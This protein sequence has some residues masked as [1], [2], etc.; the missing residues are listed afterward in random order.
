MS[1]RLSGPHFFPA[2]LLTALALVGA[3]WVVAAQLRMGFLPREY[4]MWWARRQT[5]QACRFAPTVILGDSRAAAG[6]LP[7]RIAGSTNLAQ[8]G[9]SPIET[10]YITQDILT[11]PNAPRRVILSLSPE[12]V[13]QP[14][15]F[16]NRTGLYGVLTFAQLEEI[17]QRSRALGDTSI[18]RPAKFGDWDAMLDNLLHAIDFPSF[19]TTYVVSELAIGRLRANRATADET[20]RAGGQHGYGTADGCDDVAADAEIRDFVPSPLLREYFGRLLDAYAARGIPVDFVAVPMNRATYDR[21]RADVVAGFQ[22]YLDGLA[23][24]H[25]NFRLL[26]GAV[27]A[28]D[29]RYFGDSTHLNREGAELVSRRVEALLARSDAAGTA[30]ASQ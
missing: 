19:Y 9:A 8:G 14:S 29:D 16:W 18:Y 3:F 2:A 1:S 25:P 5:I 13:M 23:A 20:L 6:L 27:A 7:A 26:T 17:R 22:A 10:Y 28:L 24:A 30:A 15:F 21:M 12:M 11:C 4:A